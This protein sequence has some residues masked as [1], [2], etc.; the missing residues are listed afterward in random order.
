MSG[1]RTSGIARM[2]GAPARRRSGIRSASIRSAI[3][4]LELGDRPADA[5]VDAAGE[6]QVVEEVGAG[7]VEGGRVVEDRRV[8]VGAADQHVD[9]LA[10]ADRLPRDLGVVEGDPGGAL[11]RRVEAQ[12]LLHRGTRERRV[13]HQ[14]GPL[15][16]VVEQ[17]V[18]GVAEQ[19]DGR[20]EAG[21]QQHPADRHQLDRPE[22]EVPV[23][24]GGDER[25]DQVVA[26]LGAA[27]LED[28]LE[29]PDHRLAAAITSRACIGERK[30]GS[31][32]PSATP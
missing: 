12:R 28:A 21:D 1:P 8:A 26:R 6:R 15:V 18:D 9:P 16:R 32:L 27:Q 24:L 5:V 25:A 7:E 30:P 20:L 2:R 17:R 14:R 19:V 29:Q 22:L 13:G 10:A 31:A 4:A 3:V 11:D 23:A